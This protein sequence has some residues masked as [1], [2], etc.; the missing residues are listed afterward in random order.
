M[1]R[2]PKFL[3]A[4]AFIVLGV[5]LSHLVEPGVRIEAVTLAGDTP[6]L[7]FLPDGAGP[8]QV[9]LL[10]HGVTASKETLFRFGEAL[11]AAGFV[12]YAF[13]FPGHGESGRRASGREIMR[14]PEKL[15]QALGGVDVFLGHSM[16]AYVGSLAAGNG[17]MIPRL[18]IAVGAV[19]RFGEHGPPL[20]LLAGRFEEAVPSAWLKRPTEA[21]RVIS[22]WS[23][24]ALEPYDPYLVNTAV[25]AACAAVGRTPPAAPTR[26]L[27][28]LAG[29]VLGTL[30]ALGLALWLPELPSRWARVRGPLVAVIVIAAAACTTATWFGGMP[31]LRRIPQQ[32]VFMVMGVLVIVGA[33][34]L[35]V[36]RWSFAALVAGAGIGCL[37]VGLNL[38]ALFAWCGAMVLAWGALAGTLAARH[39]S[40]RD[41]DIAMAV[42]VGYALGQWM[43][44]L[45]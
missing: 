36:P 28:R 25:E 10:A 34:K 29:L 35:R 42:F 1:A 27:W 41:G 37:V 40:P 17:T 12:C 38:L 31:V 18:F 15:A 39:G 43:P 3:A 21:R 4:I 19:P 13:D 8:H 32:I 30:G 5:A 33:G 7:H 11:A 23:D 45:Y 2:T 14:T 44:M 24:H 16:G 22:P 20:L 9:A 26:W 6:A